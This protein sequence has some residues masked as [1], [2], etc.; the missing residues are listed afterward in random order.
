MDFPGNLR[1][2]RPAY[3]PAQDAFEQIVAGESD[4]AHGAAGR[5]EAAQKLQQQRYESLR[6]EGRLSQ[7]E[8]HELVG[9]GVLSA[10]G[11]E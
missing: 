2:P 4:T 5:V 6:E 3:S 7:S 1:G 11:I 10:E 8:I 9:R